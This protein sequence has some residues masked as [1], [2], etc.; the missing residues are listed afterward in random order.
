MI[1]E[2][3]GE[4]SKLTALSRGRNLFGYNPYP[5]EVIEGFNRNAVQS[6]IS[7]MRIFD[8][9]NDTANIRSTIKYV[10][11]NGGMADCTVCYTV[12]PKF[13][14]KT[15][16]LSMLKGKRL[17]SNI[18][19]IEYFVKMAKE[20]EE[21]GADMITLKDMKKFRTPFCEKF[22]RDE[23]VNFIILNN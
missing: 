17:P 9:L 10:K 1:K 22:L 8:A 18:F 23:L 11:E 21:M 16:V 2:Q 19:T 7:I 6:G 13:S 4:V 3:I 20:L 12:D 15:K 14:N 5:E